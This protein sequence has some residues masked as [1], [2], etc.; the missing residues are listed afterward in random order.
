M[1]DAGLPP[2]LRWRLP[3]G[4]SSSPLEWPAP[5]RLEILRPGAGPGVRVDSGYEEGD[6]IPDEL[7]TLLE[8]CLRLTDILSEADLQS[9][10]AGGHKL[11]APQGS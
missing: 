3:S 8:P 11:R 10:A 9:L 2:S 7:Q 4:W 6:E 5:G 1:G